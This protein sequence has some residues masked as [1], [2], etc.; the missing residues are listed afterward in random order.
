[1]AALYCAACGD[2]RAGH[3]PTQ[4]ERDAAQGLAAQLAALAAQPV[5]AGS[6]MQVMDVVPLLTLITAEGTPGSLP[7]ALAEGELDACVWASDEVAIY[8]GCDLGGHI[9]EGTWSAQMRS[10]QQT[11]VHAELVDVFMD[12]PYAHGSVSLDTRLSAGAELS[13]SVNVGVLWTA[14]DGEMTLDAAIRVDGL[15]IGDS[16]GCATGGTITITSRVSDGPPALTT[17]WFGPGCG[18]VHIAP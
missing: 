1:M 14:G 3:V 15:V 10:P 17:V 4:P 2:V 8:T 6:L 9:V 11:R 12:S 13:G 16:D 18:D 7:T 5:D